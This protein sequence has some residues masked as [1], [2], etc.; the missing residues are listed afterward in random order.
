[1]KAAG[2]VN[3]G[4]D[5]TGRTRSRKHTRAPVVHPAAAE[6][7]AAARAFVGEFPPA[8]EL[9]LIGATRSAIDDFARTVSAT[10]GASFGLHR[11][12][13]LQLAARLAQPRLA[14]RG[15]A[16]AGDLATAAI[17]TRVTF[18]VRRS[19]GLPYFAPVAHLPGFG[20]ALAATIDELRRAGVSAEA[21]AA[22]PAP[23]P[24]LAALLTAID[25]HRAANDL[26]DAATLL[27]VAI[28]VIRTGNDPLVGVPVLLLDVGADA[29]F[30]RDFIEALLAAAPQ[31]CVTQPAGEPGAAAV[32]RRRSRR[33]ASTDPPATS[34]ARLRCCLFADPPAPAA[35]FDDTVRFFSAPGEGRE[36]I[37]IARAVLDEA[38][39]GVAFDDMAVLLRMPDPYVPLLDAAFARAT[40]PAYFAHGTRRPDPAGRA[41]LALLTCAANGCSAT[42]FS[43]YL[44]L[45][46]APVAQ[47][48]EASDGNAGAP[49]A[50]NEPRPTA[51]QEPAPSPAPLQ[52]SRLLVDAAVIGGRDRWERRLAGLAA[53]TQAQHAA[54]CRHDAE[55]ARVARLERNLAE[56]DRFRAFALPV[57]DALAALPT[58]APWDE[59][60]DALGALAPRVLAT[61]ERVVATL[62]ELRPL[63]RSGPVGLDEVRLVLAER[64]VTVTSEP[65]DSR[66]GRVFVGG[67]DD[68]R[69]RTFA[70]VFVPG[71]AERIFPQRPRED[72]LLLDALRTQLSPALARQGERVQR[73]RLR[74]RLGIGAATRRLYLS[75][76]RLDV[77]E[78][79]PR[80]ASFYGLDVARA[81]LG[82]MPNVDAFERQLSDATGAR[83]AWPAVDDPARA[84]DAMEHDLAVLGPLLR[85]GDRARCYGRAR[86]LLTVN[87]HLGRS[88]RT[89][90][91]RWQQ[92]AWSTFDGLVHATEATTAALAPHRLGARPY[93]PSALERFARCPYQFYL[94]GI[95]GLTPRATVEAPERMAAATRGLLVHEVQAR[96]L[97]ALNT[98]DLLPLADDDVARADECLDAVLAATAARYR[99][100]LAPPIPHVW[101]DELAAVRDDLRTWLRCLASDRAWQF[102]HAELAFGLPA[103]ERHD[104]ASITAP[105]AVAAGVVLRGA[106][107]LVERHRRDATLRVTDHKTGANVIAPG[108]VVGGGA[109]L[110]P[111]LYALA[112]ETALGEPVAAAR[113]F[114]CSTRGGFAE[115]SVALDATARAAAAAVLQT[116]DES[117]GRSFLP[118]VP[119]AGE[120][121]RCD[122]AAV[123]GPY[124]E[125]RSARKDARRLAALAQLRE[126]K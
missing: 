86:Y 65:P 96:T 2:Q 93:S 15:L 20:R 113:L 103:D 22:A 83:L 89:R 78:A 4:S 17:A 43:E 1:M 124:E 90:Y 95:Y 7:L 50:S 3:A 5:A 98:S 24:D 104:P 28:D 101:D 88:L 77:V 29:R 21:L 80:V 58:L 92:E 87:D 27:Q 53:E 59:W 62:D 91:A 109:V 94:A 69:G 52:W 125:E 75:Y 84:I 68:V 30:E 85:E 61:P 39:A 126:C 70:V 32:P 119:R 97:R 121:S 18:D 117:I 51:N 116:I 35:A 13:P 81:M 118:P 115:R 108:V 44:S 99:E 37:E 42:D 56:L 110:Q 25:A 60:L 123:C 12:T 73:E 49:H 100:A 34:L 102:R 120:C 106:I 48:V 36:C 38:R 114:Y 23:G 6:R 55:S 47:A 111:V 79:R 64:L 63:G 122:F 105:V 107:D 66:Y 76:P 45:A 31:A 16:H 71:L 67:L 19:T 72:P 57:I 9:L 82:R 11:F 33:G 74:L 41:F 46:Q 112:A 26:I 8:T 14:V 10:R 54:A 40:V